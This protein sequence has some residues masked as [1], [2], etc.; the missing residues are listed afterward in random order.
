MQ[1]MKAPQLSERESLEDKLPMLSPDALK[2]LKVSL[3][4]PSL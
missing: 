1:Y 2:F 4:L 3:S